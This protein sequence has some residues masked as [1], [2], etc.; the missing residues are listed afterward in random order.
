VSRPACHSNE[1]T[2]E[3]STMTREKAWVFSNYCKAAGRSTSASLPTATRRILLGALA[4]ALPLLPAPRTAWAADGA[5]V[6]DCIQRVSRASWASS[7]A[8]ELIAAVACKGAGDRGVGS[9]DFDRSVEVLR[10]CF[11]KVVFQSKV[12]GTDSELIAATACAG[13]VDAKE[14]AECVTTVARKFPNATGATAETLAAMA[15][16]RGNPAEGTADCVDHVAF[17]S[18]ASGI[19]ADVLAAI[20]CGR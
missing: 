4:A 18:S 7:G 17:R 1:K 5:Q 15:C 16:S 8:R 3:E 20:A 13:S 19:G 6:L 2:K 12:T 11:E 14:T 9:P 10:D